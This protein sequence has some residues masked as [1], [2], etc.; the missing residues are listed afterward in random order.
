MGGRLYNRH[1]VDA[2]RPLPPVSTD[3]PPSA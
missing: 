1:L 3:P 2:R